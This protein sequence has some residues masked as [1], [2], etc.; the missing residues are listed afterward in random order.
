MNETR[1]EPA[2]AL[3][4]R[5]DVLSRLE[6]GHPFSLEFYGEI[7]STNDRAKILGASGAPAW[8]AVLARRQSKGRG[9]LGREFHSPAGGVYLSL[10]LR[11]DCGAA[12]AGLFTAA[13]AVAVCRAV[14][15]L[16]N[17]DCG[18]KWP[19][20]LLYGG[21][22]VC[23]ILTEAAINPNGRF[24]FVVIGVGLNLRLPA[25]GFPPELPNA[26]ALLLGGEPGASFAGAAAALLNALHAQLFDMPHRRFLSEY[27]ERSVLTGKSVLVLQSGK[28]RPAVVL[29]IDERA[30]L[31][32]KYPDGT[33]ETLLSGEISIREDDR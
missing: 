3:E 19:N 22:K 9:R 15:A 11:P 27:R 7:G 24:N 33:Q 10:L 6:W 31:C 16:C 25:G 28:T 14:S 13:A 23:G 21:K 26:G 29:G 4:V 1:P 2:F 17:L 18:I 5:R 30:G 32:V 20:D 8:T 12:D